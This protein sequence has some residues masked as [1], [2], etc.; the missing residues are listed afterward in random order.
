[1]LQPCATCLVA[2]LGWARCGHAGQP[3]GQVPCGLQRVILGNA[4]NAVL[5]GGNQRREGVGE[6]TPK[7]LHWPLRPCQGACQW[8]TPPGLFFL[9]G[10]LGWVGLLGEHGGHIHTVVDTWELSAVSP[11]IRHSSSALGCISTDGLFPC[12]VQSLQCRPLWLVNPSSA[13]AILWGLVVAGNFGL[14]PACGP[15]G[16]WFQIRS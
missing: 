5:Q 7:W 10:A 16:R 4:E 11:P 1:M 3:A 12:L 2:K 14:K 8:S 9:R 6:T 13:V 15:A